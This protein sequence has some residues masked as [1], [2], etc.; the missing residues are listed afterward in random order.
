MKMAVKVIVPILA[1]LMLLS[2][3]SCANA[4][5]IPP[6]TKI[7]I[8]AVLGA[9]GG[10]DTT[11]KYVVIGSNEYLLYYKFWGTLYIYPGTYSYSSLPPTLAPIATVNYVDVCWGTYN[12]ATNQGCYTFYEVWTLSSGP[13]FVGFDNPIH[14]TGDFLAYVGVV[15]VNPPWTAASSH[16]IVV[17]IGAYAGQVIDI[18]SPNLFATPWNGYWLT[19]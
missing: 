10:A 6:P 8:T 4:F 2:V 9:P 13:N 12:S 14:S 15:T 11:V 19:P 17:G 7:P 3:A 18:A 5:V 16:I 1:L